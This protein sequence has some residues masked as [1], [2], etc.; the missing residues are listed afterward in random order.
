MK[1]KGG[2]IVEDEV[3]NN[4]PGFSRI[5]SLGCFSLLFALSVFKWVP[6][7]CNFFVGPLP[8]ASLP[9]NCGFRPPGASPLVL[10]QFYP[11]QPVL[12]NFDQFLPVSTHFDQSSPVSTSF[13]PFSPVLTVFTCFHLFW[14]VFKTVF[15]N[16]LTFK[17][18]VKPFSPVLNHL[19][20]FDP[21]WP[22]LT[23]SDPYWPIRNRFHIFLQTRCS[24][25]CS[26]IRFV[27]H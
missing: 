20:Y 21:C 8:L 6:L 18:H 5:W 7:P 13:C 19:N 27:I 15:T 14:S 10:T 9:G 11:F 4:C 26:K 1:D 16:I 17:N 2:M 25:G 22:T 3:R 24:Q 12:N 23:C